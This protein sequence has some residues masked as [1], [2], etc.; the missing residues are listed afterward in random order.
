MPASRR[1]FDEWLEAVAANE[2]VGFVPEF[3]GPQHIHSF[4]SFLTVPDRSPVPLNLV[5]LKRGGHPLAPRSAAM[6]RAATRLPAA[7]PDHNG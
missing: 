7:E 1:N 5:Y 3:V 6:A 4:V 2:G